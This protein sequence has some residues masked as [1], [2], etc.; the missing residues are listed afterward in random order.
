MLKSFIKGLL[1]GSL[2]GTLLT[3]NYSPPPQQKKN[4]AKRIT[5]KT[6]KAQSETGNVMNEAG[7]GVNELFKK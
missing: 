4:M 3:S 1:T 2:V 7:S 5:G 6:R